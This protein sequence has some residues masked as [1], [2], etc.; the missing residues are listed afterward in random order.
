MPGTLCEHCTGLCCRYIALPIDTPRST[1]DFDDIRWYLLHENVS[2]FVEDDQW[3]V[4]FVTNCRHLLPDHRCGIY[5]TRPRIC[6]QYTT[7]DCDYHSGDYG[8]Q[9]HFTCAEHLD[10]YRALHGPRAGKSRRAAAA[11][12]NGRNGARTRRTTKRRR[13]GP[14][15]APGSKPFD[16]AALRADLRG[17]P[18]PVLV[19]PRLRPD[20]GPPS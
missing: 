13:G 11:A 9:H 19:L 12:R 16:Y 18:L 2:V 6:R 17:V 4:S 5:E 1:G 10:E 8:W 14:L 15:R 20:G 7:D 3:Y